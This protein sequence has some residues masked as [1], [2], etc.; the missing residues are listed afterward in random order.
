[1]YHCTRTAVSR[2]LLLPSLQD[3][4]NAATGSKW[5][6][7]SF[8][9]LV[10]YTSYSSATQHRTTLPTTKVATGY[11]R[12][13]QQYKINDIQPAK[14][15]IFPVRGL[16]HCLCRVLERSLTRMGQKVPPSAIPIRDQSRGTTPLLLCYVDRTGY[17]NVESLI[18]ML[19]AVFCW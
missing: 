10:L 11:Q 17:R 6:D 19:S 3:D 12:V 15:N 5:F 2:N 4:R 8:G 18:R 9:S 7:W 14:A 13:I 16:F 1:M